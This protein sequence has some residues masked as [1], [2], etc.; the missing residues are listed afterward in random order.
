MCSLSSGEGTESESWSAKL[1]QTATAIHYTKQLVYY[2]LNINPSPFGG[3][4][5]LFITWGIYL[6][7]DHGGNGALYSR[8]WLAEH[9][10]KS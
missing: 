3:E 10:V 8:P 4:I 1:L 9:I 2:I 7:G 5:E 6:A